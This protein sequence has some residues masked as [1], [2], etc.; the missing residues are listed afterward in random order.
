MG[1]YADMMGVQGGSPSDN[2]EQLRKQQMESL[3]MQATSITRQLDV[4]AK[5]FPAA[6]KEL[7]MLQQGVT[8]V[9]VKIIGSSQS[10][11]QAP[12]GALG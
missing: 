1:R 9:L 11:S 2:S 8:K 5:Q 12:T 4:M 10:E 7:Q 6:A 3:K